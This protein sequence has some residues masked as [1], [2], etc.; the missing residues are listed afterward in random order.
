MLSRSLSST[1]AAAVLVASSSFGGA[2]AAPPK[3]RLV[4]LGVL[5]SGVSSAANA[6]NDA[7]VIVGHSTGPEMTSYPHAVAWIEG[8]I[9]DLT[10]LGVSGATASA[11]NGPGT[12]VGMSDE[13]GLNAFAWGE[14]RLSPLPAKFMCCSGALGVNDAGVIV[15]RAAISQLG[16]PNEAAIWVDGVFAPLPSLGFSYDVPYAINNSGVVV[17]SSDDEAGY[18]PVVWAGDGRGGTL[19]APPTVLPTFGGAWS[20]ALAINDDGLIVGHSMGPSGSR[21]AAWRHGE[22]AELPSPGAFYS[23]AYAVN[24]AEWIVGFAAAP[25]IGARAT[26]WIEGEA[27]DLNTL[28]VGEDLPSYELYDARGINDSGRIV[29]EAIIDGAFRGYLLIPVAPADLNSDGVVDGADL[30]LLLSAWGRCGGCAADIDG[31]GA[32]DGAD[33]GLLLAGWSG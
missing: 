11:V 10:G 32:V 29:G 5:P 27:H 30:G 18:Q 1:A 19:E 2:P 21:A 15:G 23:M 8:E 16:T 26:L 4:E 33:L 31:S 13:L 9:V 20:E 25:V 6:I 24:E 17:G 7:G 14:G 12:I 22:I 3:F 28:V